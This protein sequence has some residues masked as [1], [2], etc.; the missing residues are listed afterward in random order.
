MDA[1][2]GRTNVRGHVVGTFVAVAEERIAVCHQPGEKAFE[3]PEHFGVCILLHDKARGGMTKEKRQDTV[4]QTASGCPLSDGAGDFNEPAPASLE[5]K[6]G[7]ALTKH[8]RRIIE[9]VQRCLVGWREV[10]G[11]PASCRR[12]HTSV[13]V[14]ALHLPPDHS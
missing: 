14:A 6:G 7:A 8:R 2:Q 4:L 1:G 11:L 9:C 13:W 10:A 12:S 5:V 3:I